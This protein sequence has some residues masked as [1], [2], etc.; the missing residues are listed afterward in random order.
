MSLTSSEKFMSTLCS[1]GTIPKKGGRFLR[2]WFGLSGG[3]VV[4][5]VFFELRYL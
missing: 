3:S 5:R 1:V 4:V 2:D